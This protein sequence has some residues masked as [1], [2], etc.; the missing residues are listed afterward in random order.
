[1]LNKEWID[2]IPFF[3]MA[4]KQI[5]NGLGAF[6]GLVQIIIYSIYYKSTKWEEDEKIQTEVQLSGKYSGKLSSPKSDVENQVWHIRHKPPITTD[7]CVC[8]WWENYIAASSQDSLN[9]SFLLI[10]YYSLLILVIIFLDNF[11]CNHKQRRFCIVGFCSS[12]NIFWFQIDN[13]F[14]SVFVFPLLWT[15]IQQKAY[16]LGQT[17]K[18]KEKML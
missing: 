2:L 6:S 7:F 15:R 1:M 11:F 10:F 17:N 3:S 18:K 13:L 16:Y 12:R 14:S 5:P 8:F 4:M 9:F